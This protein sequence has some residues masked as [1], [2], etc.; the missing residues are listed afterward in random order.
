MLKTI[1]FFT[2]F[3]LSLV[4]PIPVCAAFLLLRLVGLGPAT[5]ETLGS[6]IRGWARSIIRASGTTLKVSGLENVP[7]DRRVVFMSNHQG[8]MDIIVMLACMPRAT[9]FMA[10][11]QAM[12][13][14]FV[15]L[16][17]IAI[18]SVFIDRGSIARG[19]ESIDRGVANIGRG[20][21]LT[22]FPEG[23]RSRGPAML[24]F[25]NGSFKLATRAGAVIVPV[26]MDGTWRIWEEH[27]RIRSARVRFTVHP[28]IPTEGLD[29]EAR[30]ALPARV[31]SAIEAGLPAR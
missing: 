23:T 7:R 18:G 14:P 26:T 30:K 29:A 9:G 12:W 4:L 24:P 13:M 3:W 2:Y 19:K 27:K 8:D 31:R 6:I 11:S 28:P 15:N 16:W 25:R 10:K 1:L 20:W 17:I 5:R 21:A 22:V